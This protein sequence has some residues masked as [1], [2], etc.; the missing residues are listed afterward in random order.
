MCLQEQTV[1]VNAL[2]EPESKGNIGELLFFAKAPL[3]M[4]L[5]HVFWG[6][7]FVSK[8]CY[9][10]KRPCCSPGL[11]LWTTS[12]ISAPF[13]PFA[14]TKSKDGTSDCQWEHTVLSV[15]IKPL[16]VP[17]AQGK[18]AH[19]P[20]HSFWNTAIPCLY[21][22][23]GLH[24]TPR[25]GFSPSLSGPHCKNKKVKAQTQKGFRKSKEELQSCV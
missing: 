2:K 19:S 16:K 12:A 24:T 17:Q 23:A 22:R 21:Q 20:Q 1:K 10:V 6:F 8:A 7:V 15:D 9:P 13:C 14:I 25:N 5:C 3:E 11:V 18:L 4:S